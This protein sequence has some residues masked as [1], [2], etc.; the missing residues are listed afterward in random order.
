MKLIS[1]NQREDMVICGL[2]ALL[3]DLGI[4]ADG[5]T[6][7]EALAATYIFPDD[8]TLECSSLHMT[9]EDQLAFL[10]SIEDDIRA[11]ML[12]AGYEAIERAISH[13]K[14]GRICKSTVI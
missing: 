4:D 9:R 5:Y 12:R 8:V 13:A 10:K 1:E 6:Q 7:Q 14:S 2:T 3:C 11:A